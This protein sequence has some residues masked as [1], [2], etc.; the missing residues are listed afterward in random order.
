MNWNNKQSTNGKRHIF[1]K[2]LIFILLVVVNIINSLFKF[3]CLPSFVDNGIT[4]LMS[5]PGLAPMNCRQPPISG[6]KRP[7]DA[8]LFSCYYE[9]TDG[10]RA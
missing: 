5:C 7:V 3:D 4:D 2:V 1:L 8:C 10:V 6:V 9:G